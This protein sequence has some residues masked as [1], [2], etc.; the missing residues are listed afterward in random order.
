MTLRVVIRNY[1]QKYNDIPDY[2]YRARKHNT[3]ILSYRSKVH[4]LHMQTPTADETSLYTP[5]V[6]QN[7]KHPMDRT[8][9][10]SRISRCVLVKV[11]AANFSLAKPRTWLLA[12]RVIPS[13]R[14]D[15]LMPNSHTPCREAVWS[16]T[17]R[18][19]GGMMPAVMSGFQVVLERKLFLQP[20]R[21][22]GW[23]P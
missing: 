15:R 1:R 19:G 8:T 3:D 17:K 23:Q 16:H 4:Y 18:V 10:E 6:Y 2:C 5:R 22:V 12:V 13:N 11:N 14:R 20:Q 9:V 7:I 21:V